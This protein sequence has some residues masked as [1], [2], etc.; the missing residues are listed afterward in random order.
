M[1]GGVVGVSVVRGVYREVFVI[2]GGRVGV[3]SGR[4]VVGERGLDI[5][6]L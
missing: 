5:I 4:G 6:T 2:I 3:S 1:L